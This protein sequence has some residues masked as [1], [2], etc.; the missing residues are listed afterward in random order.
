M[1]TKS[2]I[3]DE[4]TFD[5]KRGGGWLTMYSSNS[6]IAIGLIAALAGVLWLQMQMGDNMKTNKT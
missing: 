1:S 2:L 3:S 4:N 6:K 5:G